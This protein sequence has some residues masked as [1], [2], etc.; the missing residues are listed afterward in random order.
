MSDY[1][2]KVLI[3]KIT[4]FDSFLSTALIHFP[5]RIEVRIERSSL[6]D[7]TK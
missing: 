3:D 1:E 4:Y 7:I 2:L 6:I 5:H